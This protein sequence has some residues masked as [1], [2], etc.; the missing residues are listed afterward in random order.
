MTL[1]A[2]ILVRVVPRA[3]R[4]AIAGKRGDAWLIR[5]AAAP[6]DGAANA[7]L[8]EFLADRLESPR[9]NLSIES[10]E[11]SRDKRIR[12]EGL[13]PADLDAR[14]TQLAVAAR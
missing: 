8:V 7:A 3:G 9:R 12:V 4:T 6:V 14:M 1:S 2:T 11:K 10:G 5:L 13:S